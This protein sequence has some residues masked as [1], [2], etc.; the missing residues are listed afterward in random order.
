VQTVRTEL[1]LS[2]CADCADCELSL[3][4]CADCADCVS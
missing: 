1:S 3:S 4:L 2:L